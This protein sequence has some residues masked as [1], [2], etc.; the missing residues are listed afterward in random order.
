MQIY[1]VRHGETEIGPDLLYPEDAALTLLG[2]RQAAIT[3]EA[4]ADV[5]F[6]HIFT[7]GLRR[8]KETAAPMVERCGRTPVAL[9]DLDEVRIGD[10]RTASQEIK[11]RRI[12]QTGVYSDFSEFN[13]ESAAEF[14]KRIT[15]ALV[16]QVIEAIPDDDAIV[17]LVIHGGTMG[18][19]LDY[20]DGRPFD[21]RL[22]RNVPNGGIALLS[23]TRSK[24]I[25][26]VR[27]PAADH[28]AEVGV[29]HVPRP[30]IVDQPP[31]GSGEDS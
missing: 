10:L 24:Q 29:T 26:V 31:A 12:Y 11:T 25:T 4:L 2:H 20:A 23:V 19:I 9:E 21:P 18:V 8:A 22:G 7:S 16:H 13:G 1:L 17:A 15:R 5:D 28:L 14:E 30:A 3:A 27:Q 6:T